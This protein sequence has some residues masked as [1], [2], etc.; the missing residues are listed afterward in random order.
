MLLPN[1]SEPA[2]GS[3]MPSMSTGGAATKAI[4]KQIV[5]ASKHGIMIT[6]NQP[7]YRRLFVLV[8]QLQ[9]WSQIDALSRLCTAVVMI[10]NKPFWDEL[11]MKIYN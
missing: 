7:T 9:N 4:T 1:N 5:A 10:A 8:I 3:R 6:P 11:A 2:T